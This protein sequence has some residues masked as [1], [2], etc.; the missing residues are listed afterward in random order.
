MSEPKFWPAASHRWHLK[1]G[2]WDFLAQAFDQAERDENST[3]P[4]FMCVYDE[5]ISNVT[6]YTL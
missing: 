4:K 2:K 6:L 3:I 1:E 5:T